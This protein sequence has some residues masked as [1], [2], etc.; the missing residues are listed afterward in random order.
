MPEPRTLFDK[1]WHAHLVEERDGGASLVYIDSVMNHNSGRQTS[2]AF[3]TAGGYPGFWMAPDSPARDKQPTDNWGDFHAGTSGGYYQSANPGGAR[4]DL[5]RGR[6]LRR[7]RP[8][9]TSDPR[10]SYQNTRAFVIVLRSQFNRSVISPSNNPSS[11]SCL[12]S[13]LMR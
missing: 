12:T 2:A 4:F 11:H 10:D 8:S 13:S 6:F 9:V 5:L 7:A 1:I 3:Q